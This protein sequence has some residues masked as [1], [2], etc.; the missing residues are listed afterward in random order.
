MQKNPKQNKKLANISNHHK[1]LNVSLRLAL[2][3]GQR[4]VQYSVAEYK[5]K[6]ALYA[7]QNKRNE[8]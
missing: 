2:V 3:K 6:H 8:R 5:Y 7:K 1:S 4:T